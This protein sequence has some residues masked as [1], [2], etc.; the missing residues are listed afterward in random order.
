MTT[1]TEDLERKLQKQHEGLSDIVEIWRVWNS[2]VRELEDTAINLKRKIESQE[3]L[4]AS[5]HRKIEKLAG[6]LHDGEKEEG[7]G[8]Q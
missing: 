1:G 7:G 3:E 6:T 5:L 2:H 4:I 8:G